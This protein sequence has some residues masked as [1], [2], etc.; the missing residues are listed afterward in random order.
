MLLE[1]VK[2]PHPP[3]VTRNG[4]GPHGGDKPA[5]EGTGQAEACPARPTIESG[6]QTQEVPTTRLWRCRALE[7]FQVVTPGRG[8]DH[9]RDSLARGIGGGQTGWG[10]VRSI[11][12]DT[13]RLADFGQ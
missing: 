7:R 11:W 2:E 12:H 13:L 5:S 4:G 9:D 1:L 8:I 6:G 3:V 10:V